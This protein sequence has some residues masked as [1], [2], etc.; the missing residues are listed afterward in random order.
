MS[1][2][3]TIHQSPG[4]S[5]YC[6]TADTSAHSSNKPAANLAAKVKKEVADPGNA[7]SNSG[8]L[9]NCNTE[10][11]GIHGNKNKIHGNQPNDKPSTGNQQNGASNH[12]NML[13]DQNNSDISGSQSTVG[14]SI[15]MDS[16]MSDSGNSQKIEEG[17]SGE[18]RS[19][20]D[21][22]LHKCFVC[23]KVF[24]DSKW[25]KAHMTKHRV[26]NDFVCSECNKTFSDRRN[27]RRHCR[28][29]SE[30]TPYKCEVCGKK[31]GR[32]K[33]LKNHMK[34]HESERPFVCSLCGRGFKHQHGY[35]HHMATHESGP[36]GLPHQDITNLQLAQLASATIETISGG[37]TSSR[38]SIPGG[39]A[40]LL[41]S[42]ASLLGGGA[43]VL[44][45]KVNLSGGRVPTDR[46]VQADQ[47]QLDDSMQT[48]MN[49]SVSSAAS[50]SPGNKTTS[51]SSTSHSDMANNRPSM[52]QHVSESQAL[53]ILAP[54][55]NRPNMM[56]QI[57]ESQTRNILAPNLNDSPAQTK[58]LENIPL[59]NLAAA[60][61]QGTN[62][63]HLHSIVSDGHGT[64]VPNLSSI[65]NSDTQISHMTSM[66]MQTEMSMGDS[67]MMLNNQD[68]HSPMSM[69]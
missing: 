22:D 16:L 11:D 42:G 40:S 68:L 46:H 29:H 49:S 36:F 67:R 27:F 10:E 23:H 32:N 50:G 3:S 28:L 31:C 48:D 25:L 44:G 24:T 2:Q 9:S 8:V 5:P 69:S 19:L 39:G 57:N 53:N 55:L 41:G 56:P 43:S 52:M 64:P 1:L 54:N 30:D 18:N 14:S 47:D 58:Q 21:S 17:I 66:D 35:N 60:V 26:G 20:L 37:I 38:I 15:G 33:D 62:L 4:K 45:G 61:N 65:I 59:A 7:G 12:G 63:S 6:D 34:S 51:V 13:G